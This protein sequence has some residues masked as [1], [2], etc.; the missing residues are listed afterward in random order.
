MSDNEQLDKWRQV[1]L[2]MA[3]LGDS[4]PMKSMF[5]GKLAGLESDEPSDARAHYN[6]QNILF[7]DLNAVEKEPS[8]EDYLERI[9][10]ERF[11]SFIIF[12]DQAGFSDADI[13]L[14]VEIGKRYKPV[15]FVKLASYEVLDSAEN[16]KLDD[17]IDKVYTL[18]P[19]SAESVVSQLNSDIANSL[20]DQDKRHTFLLSIEPNSPQIIAQKSEVLAHR[21]DQI[22][23]KSSIYGTLISLP[24]LTIIADLV[25]LGSEIWLFRQQLGL[26]HHIIE[27]IKTSATD[28]YNKA[29][30]V[31]HKSKYAAFLLLTEV[32]EITGLIQNTLPL[33]VQS[34]F[35]DFLALL[36]LIG[37]VL[38]RRNSFYTTRQILL[39][40]LD[41]FA[42]V[43]NEIQQLT[44]IGSENYA[45]KKGL[46]QILQQ[47]KSNLN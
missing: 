27:K 38:T 18:N 4:S 13:D 8:V 1:Q 17:K 33:F 19:D 20:K 12:R 2:N 7:W 41:E 5:I 39:N 22:A 32:H 10:I 35:L 36:P 15:Y 6:N 11:D 31:I 37:M 9:N 14:A 34:S 29:L 30:E 47:E 23:E 3:I 21:S 40:I 43:A 16:V 24:S 46:A 26:D 42:R 44:S 45:Q 28:Y 25:L